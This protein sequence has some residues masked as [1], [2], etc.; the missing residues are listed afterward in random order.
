MRLKYNKK[1]INDL[2]IEFHETRNMKTRDRITYEIMPLC[3]FLANK[4]YTLIK[5]TRIEFDDLVQEGMLGAVYCLDNKFDP[6]I[7]NFCDYASWWINQGMW[8]HMSKEFSIV[9]H[10]LNNYNAPLLT[11]YR[12]K[13]TEISSENPNM[14]RHEIH[15]RMSEELGIELHYIEQHHNK[16]RGEVSLNNYIYEEDEPKERQEMIEDKT[17]DTEKTVDEKIKMEKM[18]A[19]IMNIMCSFDNKRKTVTLGRILTDEKRTLEDIGKELGFTRERARQIEVECME[20][21]EK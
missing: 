19:A 14:T 8:R 6:E 11:K 15:V 21:S 17:V 9:T 5:R 13:Y 4:K 1:L 16:L 12:T 18:K 7:G 3:T 2:A 10:K 20:R